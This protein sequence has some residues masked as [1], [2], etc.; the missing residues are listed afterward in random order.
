MIR[1]LAGWQ[2]RWQTR[3]TVRHVNH[4]EQVLGTLL[5]IQIW[6]ENQPQAKIAEAALL[7]EIDRLEEVFSRFR[8]TSELNRWQQH[9][10]Q[11]TAVSADLGKVLADSLHWHQ[12]TA[13]AFHP[14]ADALSELWKAGAENDHHPEPAAI[15]QVLEK[16][17]DPLWTV[18]MQDRNG[19]GMAATKHTSLTVNFN[20][21]AKGYIVDAATRAAHAC[22]GVKEVLVNLGGD[23]RHLGEKSVQ[24]LIADPFSNAINAD[25][26]ARLQIKQ[27]GVATSG[28][29]H[30]GFRVGTE[31]F[32]H[33]L[34]PR[35][36]QPVEHVVSASVIASDSAT[37]DVL[38][39][40]F[41]ILAP[42]DSLKLADQIPGIGCLL[43][44]QDHQVH[45]NGLWDRHLHPS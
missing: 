14:A 25:P 1:E 30:R 5:E 20:A 28:C 16:L 42:F 15:Q 24:V 21:F 39:T 44:T 8:E 18:T 22:P 4:Y 27:Q 29:T 31:W 38:A 34:D 13:G 45:S 23:L 37:A 3:G 26:I 41:S 12:M 36:G 19:H 17:Q 7:A 10:G 11:T 33:L 2:A 40:A 9:P 35:T 32:S 43:V 6:A